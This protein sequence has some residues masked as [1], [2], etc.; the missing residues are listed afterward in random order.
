MLSLL[1]GV[2]KAETASILFLPINNRLKEIAKV[3]QAKWGINCISNDPYPSALS[4]KKTPGLD[5]VRKLPND[6]LRQIPHK[7]PKLN[8]VPW[9]HLRALTKRTNTS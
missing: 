7:A 6:H 1:H 5:K 9:T 4:T 8:Q 2:L 3:F